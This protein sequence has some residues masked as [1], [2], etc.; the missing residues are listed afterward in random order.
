MPNKKTTGRKTVSRF[1]SITPVHDDMIDRI[2]EKEG[3]LSRSETVRHAIAELHKRV[4]PDYIYNRSAS[5]LEKRKKVSESAAQEAQPDIEFANEVYP[6][7][8]LV[9]NSVGEDCL[10]IHGFANFPTAL[11]LSEV[12]EF[13]KNDSGYE[14]EHKKKIDEGTS[15]ESQM[16]QY[17]VDYMKKHFDMNVPLYETKDEESQSD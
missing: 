4:L 3:H 15:V 11:R 7:H 10:I 16:N 1:F 6:G 17:M 13:H 9:Q 12:K 14:A 5:D 8:M 2:A